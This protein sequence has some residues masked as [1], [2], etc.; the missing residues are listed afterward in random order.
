MA[1]PY[2]GPERIQVAKHLLATGHYN[3]NRKV[4]SSQ[5]VHFEDPEEAGKAL[6]MKMLAGSSLKVQQ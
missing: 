1:M 6:L 4:T 5:Y 2:L 3:F